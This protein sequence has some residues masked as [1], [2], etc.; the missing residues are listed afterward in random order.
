MCS[1]DSIT[2]N[3]LLIGLHLHNHRDLQ[4]QPLIDLRL[5]EDPLHPL[6]ERNLNLQDDLINLLEKILF[7]EDSLNPEVSLVSGDHKPEVVGLKS[8]VEGLAY[9]TLKTNLP[10]F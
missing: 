1:K 6:L 2:G 9:P 5:I 8:E 4:L 3:T 7:L 10:L